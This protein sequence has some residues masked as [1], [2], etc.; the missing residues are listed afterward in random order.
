MTVKNYSIPKLSSSELKNIFQARKLEDLKGLHFVENT[1]RKE[2]GYVFKLPKKN[3]S[4]IVLFSGGLDSTTT[5]ALLIEEFKLKVFPIFFKTGFDRN[6]YEW[7]AANIMAKYFKKRYKDFFQPIKVIEYSPLYPPVKQSQPI[8]NLSY[9]QLSNGVRCIYAMKYA[10]QLE[11]F[12]HIKIRTIFTCHISSDGD[13][14]TDQTLSAL[15]KTMLYLC[16][17]TNDFSWQITALGL[18]KELGYHY[19]KDFEISWANKHDIPLEITRTSCY[20]NGRYHCGE[21][22]YCDARKNAFKKA[23]VLDKTLYANERFV[24]KILPS[25]KRKLKS[26]INL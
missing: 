21:C 7:E 2:R 9:D 24:T 11:K 3:E 6:K 8:W 13:V 20:R 1:L 23:G 5:C 15:R 26:I 19:G 12:S 16:L 22:A 14:I 17:G 4:V 10:Y 25:M 18:E